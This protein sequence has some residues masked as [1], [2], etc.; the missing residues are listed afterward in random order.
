M[1]D[2]GVTTL[3]NYE[4]YLGLPSMVGRNKM[5]SFEHLKQKVWKRLQE[6]EGKL[7]SQT[8]REVLIKLVIQAI[9]TYTMSCFKLPVRLCHEIEILIQKFWWG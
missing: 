6:W 9:P 5:E 1:D 7:L 8:K 4:E 3:K 2:L